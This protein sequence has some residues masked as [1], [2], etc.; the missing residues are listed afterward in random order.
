MR[1]PTRSDKDPQEMR[2]RNY[3]ILYLACRGCTL[4][5]ISS[6]VKVSKRSVAVT[7]NRLRIANPDLQPFLREYR[8]HPSKPINWVNRE[9]FYFKEFTYEGN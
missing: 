2:E 1:C 5:E 7:I 6:V 8:A 9:T 4:A 3:R